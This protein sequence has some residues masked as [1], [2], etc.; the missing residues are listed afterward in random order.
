MTVQGMQNCSVEF[1][2]KLLSVLHRLKQFAYYYSYLNKLIFNCFS[3]PDKN[4]SFFLAS[5]CKKELYFV[6]FVCLTFLSVIVK[7]SN[8]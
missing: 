7:H 6:Q 8:S 2:A 5:I 4:K 3:L 1:W